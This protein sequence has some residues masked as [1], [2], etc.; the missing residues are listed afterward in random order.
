MEEQVTG[1]LRRAWLWGGLAGALAL[2]LSALVVLYCWGADNG[3]ILEDVTVEQVPVGGMT[4]QGAQSYLERVLLPRYQE[5]R[6]LLCQDGGL[7][8]ELTWA[9]LGAQVD[10]AGAVEAAYAVGRD[11]GEGF[12]ARLGRGWNRLFGGTAVDIRPTVQVDQ[13]QLETV[14]PQA[15]QNA[16]Y[17]KESGQVLEG[18]IGVRVEREALEKLLSQ[19]APGENVHV[20][21]QVVQPEITAEELRQVL[22]RDC[23]GTYTTTVSGS[24][25]RK[26]NVR[27]SAA[28]ISGVVLCSGETFDYNAVVGQRTVE[29]GYGAAPAYVN[30]ETVSSVG[31]GI[32]QT[33]STLYMA[34]LLSNLEVV[35]RHA[36]GY[37]SGY[38]TMGM[39]ATVSWGGPEFRFRNDTAYPIRLEAAMEGNKL[40]VS[41]YGTKLDDSYVEMTY[42]VLD[43][44]EYQT[45]YQE[46]S[47]LA[48]GEQSQKQSGYTGYT[49]QTYRNVYDAEGNLLV[50]KEEARSV[51]KSRDRIV[52]VGKRRE[53][54]EETE[55]TGQAAENGGDDNG[56][57]SES[58]DDSGS[59]GDSNGSQAAGATDDP[60]PLRNLEDFIQ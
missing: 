39:D 23:L 56:G 58:G 30:G 55:N 22:F 34:V 48:E 35:E 45:R 52:L 16:R 38:I 12:W 21:V 36:H 1:R 49:V 10:L 37:V 40:T 6:I 9:D 19:A 13:A 3:R 42:Q 46:T 14:L 17:D 47:A 43:K 51:Y 54:P 15:A 50:S 4:C 20:P 11:G 31:G 57:A 18:Q 26:N 24:S 59:P 60:L 8:T 41:I 29:R 53:E 5:G 32:C 7:V 27:L 44:R 28:A 2:V 25:T 33:S